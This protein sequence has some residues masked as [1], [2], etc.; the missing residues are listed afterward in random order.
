M[1]PSALANVLR[2]TIPMHA[3]ILIKGAPGTGKTDI[4]SQAAKEQGADLITMHPVVSDPTDF[5]GMPAIVNDHAV[6]L[7]FGDLKRL[8]DANKPTVCFLDDLGQAPA[9][10]Q[11]AAMQLLLARQI[12][13]H[14]IS[15]HVTFIAATNRR[16][17]R[18]GVSTILEPVKSRFMTILELTVDVDDWIEWALQNDIPTEV[19]ALI[20]FKP[21]L[22]M[23]TEKPTADIV[24]R[25]S[26]RTVAHAGRL[27]SYGLRD[28]EVFAGACGEGWAIE[29]KGFL[30]VW[31]KLPTIES[32]LADPENAWIPKTEETA[33]QIAIAMAISRI[34]T[35][36][37]I[38]PAI[39]YLDRMPTEF[40]V[41]ALKGVVTR[42]WKICECSAF[43]N[44][45][46]KH[47]DLF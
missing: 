24:N 3:P 28:L 47:G 38:K 34:I 10:V 18:A 40:A 4:V 17:D 31:Q 16:E 30:D 20:R 42:D 35:V 43:T 25:P 23:D 21:E 39:T 29:F 33:A 36:E 26:P 41:M 6:F 11:A 46:R 19:I 37:N 12:N 15:D 5:K 8:L 45:A 9:V 1:K 7:P 32:I 2:R 22:L 44:W 27:Y 13:D 14:K